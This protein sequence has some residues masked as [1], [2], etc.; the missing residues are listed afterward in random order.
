MGMQEF[1][2]WNDFGKLREVAVGDFSRTVVPDW[3]DA[4]QYSEP[5]TQELI[6]RYAGRPLTEV[7]EAAP[8]MDL[9]QSN[10]D[11][12]AATYERLGVTVHRPR[13]WTADE[14]KWLAEYQSGGHQSFPADPIWIIG[15]NVIECQFHTPV[16][17]K[18]VFPLRDLILP[19]IAAAPE[20]RHYA[21]PVTGPISGPGPVL[22]GGDILICGDAERTVLVGLDPQRSS[23]QAGIDWL[24]RCL[25]DDGWKVR[26]VPITHTAP[27]HLLGCAGVAG[28]ETLLLCREGIAGELPEPICNWDIIDVTIDEARRTGPCVVMIDERTVLVPESTPRLGAELAKRGL[29]VVPVAADG[30]AML[31]GGIRCATFVMRRDA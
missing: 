17:S 24:A 3:D 27:I 8:L 21:V 7:S 31:D 22:E 23:N 29:E 30:I 12:L 4:Y 1:G 14:S 19:L 13:A 20:A 10:L 18:E 5:A 2:V 11:D 6:R 16:R 9:V 28:P 26:A 25:S 15:R